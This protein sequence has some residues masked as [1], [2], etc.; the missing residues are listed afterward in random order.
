MQIK[1]LA[2]F[3]KAIQVGVKL[4]TIHAKLGSF[5]VREVS[6]KQTNSFALKTPKPDNKFVDSWCE[7]PKA[8]DFECD[9]TDTVKIFWGEGEK[10]ELIL[11]YKFV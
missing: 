1:T 8:K 4:E 6:I 2:D 5:G 11:T 7:Y 10:R 3:K 9:G